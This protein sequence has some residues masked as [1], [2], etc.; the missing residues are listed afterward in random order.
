MGYSFR[1]KKRKAVADLIIIFDGMHENN[2]M[3]RSRRST[4]IGETNVIRSHDPSRHLSNCRGA[5]NNEEEENRLLRCR[6]RGNRLFLS[7]L[8]LNGESKSFF[9]FF[10][11]DS[12]CWAFVSN[13]F[14]FHYPRFYFFG[15]GYSAKVGEEKCHSLSQSWGVEIYC[16]KRKEVMQAQ[17]HYLHQQLLDK[18]TVVRYPSWCGRVVL[19][20]ITFPGEICSFNLFEILTSGCCPS[21]LNTNKCVY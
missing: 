7:P 9:S 10:D 18:R 4:S 1:K 19:F 16:R 6:R 5:N 20:I 11:L 14:F 17:A 21:E 3:S 13:S 15:W 2:K 12:S 8:G